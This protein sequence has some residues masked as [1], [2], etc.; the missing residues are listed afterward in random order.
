MV[1]AA[2]SR[3]T[4]CFCS[5]PQG[6]IGLF[7][8]VA[9][10]SHLALFGVFLD[11]GSESASVQQMSQ[12][13]PLISISLIAAVQEQKIALEATVPPVTP[14]AKRPPQALAEPRPKIE[15]TVPFVSQAQHSISSQATLQTEELALERASEPEPFMEQ[16]QPEIDVSELSEKAVE[17]SAD[18]VNDILL[19]EPIY[20]PPSSSVAYHHNPRPHY[21]RAAKHRGM[22]GT[23]ELLVAVDSG[24][25]PT[26]ITI[27]HSSGFAVLD[28]EALRAVK[29]WRFE[30]ARRGGLVVTG[31][32]VVP[33]R[34]QLQG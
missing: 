24:G 29:Q 34:F 17:E 11:M 21:P 15:P 13:R 18:V 9:I 26:D 4:D 8:I 14:P 23:V 3:A 1:S 7:A 2:L 31:E 30:P 28:R 5:Y 12:H 6:N 32:V 20:T 22:E 27:K 19:L 10:L 33:I 25:R 16:M